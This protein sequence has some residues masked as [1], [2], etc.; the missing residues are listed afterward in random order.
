M[1][2]RKRIDVTLLM[3]TLVLACI[4][5]V[6]VYSSSMY[7]SM[8]RT[9]TPF[10][11]VKRQA[12]HLV[13]GLCAMLFMT[14]VNYHGFAT[15]RKGLIG[16]GF[17]LLIALLFQNHLRGYEVNRWLRIGPLLFQPSE[18]MKLFLIVFIAGSI[19]RMG[20]RIRSFSGGFL[21]VLGYIIASFALVFLE[22]DLGISA[23]LLAIGFYLL[24]IGRAKL[25]HLLAVT[26]P[27]VFG[28]V[29]L[30]TLVPY[31]KRRWEEFI[32]PEMAYQIKQSI[33]GI[34]SGG[35][36]GVGLGNS[37]QKYYFLPE[38]YTDFVFSIFAEE[39]GFFGTVTLLALMFLFVYRGLRIARMA[40][41]MFGFL[42]ASGLTMM[43]GM[44][45]FINI[46]VAIRL[47]PTTGMTLPFISYGGT[48]L[49][50][51][52]LSVGIL[53]NISKYGNYELRLSREYGRRSYRKA[54]V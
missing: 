3:V 8:D 6:M 38:M 28:V 42:L 44:Q 46:G 21:P 23:L 9:G 31:M 11:Y 50:M 20:E 41:D 49:V 19:S 4:G 37:T 10:Y 30:V 15:I 5:F 24:F 13:I 47:L 48:S 34:G 12:I 39:I 1:E 43:I 18:M 7:L 2:D 52:F 40:P 32:N 45:M 22:P 27:A 35:L 17:C 54:W 36:F 16:L 26:L 25:S 33:I 53:L 29:F 51:S 14:K